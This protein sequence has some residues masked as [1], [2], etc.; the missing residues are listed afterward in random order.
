[1]KVATFGRP[2]LLLVCLTVAEQSLAIQNIQQ[3]CHRIYNSTI[4]NYRTLAH[5][6]PAAKPIHPEFASMMR[7]DSEMCSSPNSAQSTLGVMNAG[8]SRHTSK[9]GVILPMTG[10][11]QELAQA[12]LA[13]V[14]SAFV[15]NPEAFPAT[16]LLRDSRGSE[17]GCLD[18]LADLIVNHGVSVI[19]G[20]A[21]A[22]ESNILGPWAEKLM[23]PTFLTSASRP[24]S[25]STYAFRVFPREE[26]IAATLAEY[27]LRKGFKKIAI[28]EP[29]RGGASR[30]PGL[31]K[32]EMTRRHLDASSHYTYN[33]NDYPQIETVIKTLLKINDSSRAA[34][35]EEIFREKKEAAEKAHLPFNAR[36]LVLP[37]VTEFDA[38]A[39]LD[40][41][42]MV[43]HVVK[44]LKFFGVKQLPLIGHQEWRARELI[45]P[46]EPFLTGSVFADVVGSY[47]DLPPG[48]GFRGSDSSAYFGN[49]Q[50]MASIDFQLVGRYAAVMA[51]A[52]LSNAKQP[53]RKLHHEIA[54]LSSPFVGSPPNSSAFTL[55]TS[56]W[57]VFLFRIDSDNLTPIPLP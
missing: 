34:E 2:I 42:R 36:M 52:V 4:Q 43:R 56:D 16:V 26:R 12:I 27:A 18:A 5:R 38:I 11:H 28:L 33:P 8:L 25:P 54:S 10:D 14:R 17:A 40:N 51:K 55:N 44:I 57:P 30:L 21:T 32:E 22:L 23:I 41:F 29:Q 19:L 24:A 31:L 48:L 7:I 49:P 50:G 1:M 15:D 9:I 53:R 45:D 20:G 37:P 39:I 6:L 13:G 35:L 46:P 47:A 3:S